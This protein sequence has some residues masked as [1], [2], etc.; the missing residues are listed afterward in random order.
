MVA[1]PGLIHPLDLLL[2]DR[3]NVAGRVAC[4]QLSD[5]WMLKEIF[6]CAFVIDFQGIIDYN[7]E[8]GG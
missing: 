3:K 6:L 7:L 8:V 4:L 2:K 1:I 5:E